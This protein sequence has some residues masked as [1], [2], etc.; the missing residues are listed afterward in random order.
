MNSKKILLFLF[1]ILLTQGCNDPEHSD[2]SQTSSPL[3][4]LSF[5]DSTFGIYAMTHWD[6]DHNGCL[7]VSEAQSVQALP[8]NAFAGNT[9]LQNISD[10]NSFPNLTVIGNNAFAGCTGLVSANLPNI[11][12]VGNNA[13]SGCTNLV[14]VQLPN[15]SS[16]SDN[17]FE[18]CTNLTNIVGP[19]TQNT[20]TEGAL[21]CSDNGSQAFVCVND[22]WTAKETCAERCE[23]GVCVSVSVPDHPCTEGTTRYNQYGHFFVCHNGAWIF[24]AKCA[25]GSGFLEDGTCYDSSQIC[26]KDE[27]WSM[28]CSD[29][30]LISCQRKVYPGFADYRWDFYQNCG[31]YGC[32]SDTKSCNSSD[33][34]ENGLLKCSNDNTHSLECKYGKWY[35]MENCPNGCE[36]GICIGS[37]DYC[38]LYAVKGGKWASSYPS[39]KRLRCSSDH[40]FLYSCLFYEF[41][42]DPTNWEKYACDYC[43]DG[44]CLC[45]NGVASTSG[46]C[47]S[48]PQNDKCTPGE[49]RIYCMDY[50]KPDSW[51]LVAS[52]VYK[53]TC[54][55]NDDKT[56]SFTFD[57]GKDVIKQCRYGCNDEGTDCVPEDN[58]FDRV[59]GCN[60]HDFGDILEYSSRYHF[61][62][63]VWEIPSDKYQLSYP[64]RSA[65]AFLAEY[66]TSGHGNPYDYC[67]INWGDGYSSTVVTSA[68]YGS[69]GYTHTYNKAGTYTITTDCSFNLE[70]Y[71]KCWRYGTCPMGWCD[72][73][74]AS[75]YDEYPFTTSLC[76]L[77]P[78][79][80]EIKDWSK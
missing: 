33:C 11:K 14:S 1:A 69:T 75:D 56:T 62:Q 13:F 28:K 4:C 57:H 6:V 45:K 26:D 67:H 23:N 51:K 32:N 80:I 31:I 21:K 34:T 44:L 40:K 59:R 36:D 70:F 15:A 48:E 60:G 22:T 49:T 79:L 17:A 54:T 76:D 20:C 46:N 12:T 18:G 29:N 37:E 78:E 63:T 61:K 41:S 43:V 77:I 65:A 64:F 25:K 47:V 74:C 2:N 8:D 24:E 16:I 73:E 53:Q 35:W 55:E 39:N 58:G 42:H 3:E 68:C 72:V 52:Y 30:I 5:Y 38:S 19:V 10:L 50:K 7:T 66:C 9:A 71:D 27:E